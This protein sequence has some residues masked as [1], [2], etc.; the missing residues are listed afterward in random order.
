MTLDV[1]LEDVSLVVDAKNKKTGENYY[2]A[3]PLHNDKLAGVNTWDYIE[4]SGLI[5]DNLQKFDNV[6]I[7]IWNRGGKKFKVRNLIFVLEE[8]KS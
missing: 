8:Y 2:R 1:P 4:F 5:P 7:Y 3:V 6:N